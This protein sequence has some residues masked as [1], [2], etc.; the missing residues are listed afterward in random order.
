M[1]G[2][3]KNL[4]LKHSVLLKLISCRINYIGTVQPLVQ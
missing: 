3:K 4:I 1:C 2:D